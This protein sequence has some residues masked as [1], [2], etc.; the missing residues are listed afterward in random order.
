MTKNDVL[1]LM[2]EVATARGITV[3]ELRSSERTQHVSSARRAVSV[4][5]WDKY[6]LSGSHHGA[7][8]LLEIAKYM[9]VARSTMFM[10]ARNWRLQEGAQ[11]GEKEEDLRKKGCLLQ[12]SEESIHEMAKRL[13]KRRLGEMPKGRRKE[14]GYWRSEEK[15][16]HG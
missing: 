7:V 1:T 11:D 4:I 5:L 10:S 2:E 8:P 16:N 15:V 14:L 3:D 12:Q 13:C 9:N 6:S